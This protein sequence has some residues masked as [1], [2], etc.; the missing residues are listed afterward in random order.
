MLDSQ[1]EPPEDDLLEEKIY[2]LYQDYISDW[3]KTLSAGWEDPVSFERFRLDV[4]LDI[5]ANRC[6]VM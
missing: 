2:E 4:L 3:D 6:E 5:R 1:L